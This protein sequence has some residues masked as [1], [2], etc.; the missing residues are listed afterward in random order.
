MTDA[1]DEDDDEDMDEG[2]DEDD[3]DENEEVDVGSM[4]V[5]DLRFFFSYFVLSS[6]R[7]GYTM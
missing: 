6:H 7:R 3:D 4:K 5:G 2:E 1:A